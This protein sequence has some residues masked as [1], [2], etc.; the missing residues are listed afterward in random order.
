[1]RAIL[2]PLEFSLCC[3]SIAEGPLWI[4]VARL[5]RCT[6]DGTPLLDLLARWL[7]EALLRTESPSKF[8]EYQQGS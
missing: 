7:S 8:R 4:L 6:V 1:M 3:I 2:D 5:T